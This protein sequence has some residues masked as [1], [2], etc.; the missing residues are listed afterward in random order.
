M[1]KNRTFKFKDGAEI[2]EVTVWLHVRSA[3][4]MKERLGRTVRGD[5]YGLP[6]SWDDIVL[7][8]WASDYER[9]YLYCPANEL[10]FWE[11]E[12][13]KHGWCQEVVQS[14]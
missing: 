10:W 11:D 5:D 2:K 12:E 4:P 7:E 8:R 13:E 9:Y 14:T 3:A 1:P 6:P